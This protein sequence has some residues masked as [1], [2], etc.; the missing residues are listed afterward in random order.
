M[1]LVVHRNSVICFIVALAVSNEAVTG[2]DG[3]CPV[4]IVIHPITVG[5]DNF[6][7]N[8]ADLE[9]NPSGLIVE[10]LLDE[11]QS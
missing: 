1:H 7:S 5:I 6:E 2:R 10:H 8:V 11:V 4:V 3:G 9:G